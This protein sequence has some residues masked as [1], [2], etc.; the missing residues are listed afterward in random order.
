[1][2]TNIERFDNLV[3][4]LFGELYEAFPIPRNL[5]CTDM[6]KHIEAA[7][8]N[9]IDDFNPCADEAR[10]FTASVRWL[11]NAGLIEH[12]DV[13]AGTAHDCV[14]TAKGLEILKA[15]PACLEGALGDR[16]VQAAKHDADEE[17]RQLSGQAL[18]YGI[19]LALHKF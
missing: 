7:G 11:G 15:T 4:R 16:L 1:M 10:F 18:S 12:G 9:E 2:T 3:G 13:V 5:F 6:Q 14:L 17:L 19:S 8:L